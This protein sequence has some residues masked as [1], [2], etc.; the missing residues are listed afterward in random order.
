MRIVYQRFP[1]KKEYQ[2]LLVINDEARWRETLYFTFYTPWG[3]SG[4]RLHAGRAM[5]DVHRKGKPCE[6]VLAFDFHRW[7][8]ETIDKALELEAPPVAFAKPLREL[9]EKALEQ[10]EAQSNG[11]GFVIKIK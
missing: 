4:E 2:S 10:R 7:D 1:D 3:E 6:C 8:R 11:D 5:A 9:L